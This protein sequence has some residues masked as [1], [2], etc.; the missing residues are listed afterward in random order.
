[1]VCKNESTTDIHL[2]Q[3]KTEGHLQKTVRVNADTS[4]LIQK[5]NCLKLLTPIVTQWGYT[6][7][8]DDTWLFWVYTHMVQVSYRNSYGK[9]LKN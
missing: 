1:M 9:V 3:F 6:F 2:T 8:F 7:I 5:K 4:E